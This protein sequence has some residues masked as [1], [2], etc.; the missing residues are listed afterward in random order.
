MMLV[1]NVIVWLRDCNFRGPNLGEV[2]SS[3]LGCSVL[4]LCTQST[5]SNYSTVILTFFLWKFEVRQTYLW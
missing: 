4:L 5:S 2:Y 1:W 3:I